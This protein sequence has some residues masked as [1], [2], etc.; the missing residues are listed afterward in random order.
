M[1]ENGIA[2]HHGGVDYL[3]RRKIEDGFRSGNIVA[4]VCTST[5]AVG[6]NLPAH[7]VFIMG[8]KHWT[9]NGVYLC[10]DE[11]IRSTLT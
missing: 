2:C 10:Q 8:T 1:A 3:D 9:G 4:V 5:L 7:T 6:V 11:R